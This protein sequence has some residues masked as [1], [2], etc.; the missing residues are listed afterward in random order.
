VNPNRLV[1][2]ETDRLAGTP[3]LFATRVRITKV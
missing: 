2:S 1:G 3:A